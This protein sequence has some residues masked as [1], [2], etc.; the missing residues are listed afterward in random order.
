M[1]ETFDMMD[2][3]WAAYAVTIVSTVALLGWSW[4]AMRRAEAKREETRG[5]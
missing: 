3:V 4:L 1:R 5:K 2:F